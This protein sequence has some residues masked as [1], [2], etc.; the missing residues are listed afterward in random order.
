METEAGDL[1]FLKFENPYVA[2][3]GYAVL[4]A[5]FMDNGGNIVRLRIRIAM[6]ERG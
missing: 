2:P 4:P 5:V 6:E 1:T 3:Q